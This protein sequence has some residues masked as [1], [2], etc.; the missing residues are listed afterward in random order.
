MKTAKRIL[1]GTPAHDWRADVRYVHSFGQTIKLCMERGIDLRWLFP[2]G[3]AILQQS[4]NALVRDALTFGF[5][6]LFFIDS[7]QDWE[8]EWIIRLLSYPIDCIGAPVRKKTD[9]KELYNV[10]V[11]SGIDSFRRLG[12][13]DIITAPDLAVGTGFLRMSRRAMQALWDA[14]E[15]YVGPDGIETAWIYDIRPQ[16]GE[17]VG[18]D[19][20]VCD[21]LR[22]LGIET[23][24]DPT[25]CPGHSGMKRFAGD[26]GTWFA[27]QQTAGV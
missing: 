19:T 7:D 26:F 2:P 12:Q 15:K 21:K 20:H 14:S 5:D 16:N 11:R 27:R 17:L 22:S 13:H 24:I 3:D 23:W 10:K 9:D 18:E 6:D 25:M 1:I 8:A 4:R